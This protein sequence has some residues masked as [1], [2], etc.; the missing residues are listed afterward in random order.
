MKNAADANRLHDEIVALARNPRHQ[1]LLRIGTG[2][3][4]GGNAMSDD[5]AIAVIDA[6]FH[7]RGIDNLRVCDGSIFPDSSNVNPQWTIMALADRCA[8]DMSAD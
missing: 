8:H 6:S 4:Q 3:P 2:H 1:H 5:P 7:V